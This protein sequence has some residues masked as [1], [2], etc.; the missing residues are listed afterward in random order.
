MLRL[1]LGAAGS[2]VVVLRLLVTVP[3]QVQILT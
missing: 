1:P 3:D 2:R